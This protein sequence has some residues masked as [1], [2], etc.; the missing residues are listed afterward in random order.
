MKYWQEGQSMSQPWAFESFETYVLRLTFAVFTELQSKD[1]ATKFFNL[2]RDP[3]PAASAAAAAPAFS[4]SQQ[5]QQQPNAPFP[6]AS[7]A[8]GQVSSPDGPATAGLLVFSSCASLRVVSNPVISL[9][10]C[11]DGSGADL[12]FTRIVSFRP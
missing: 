8:P 1:L 5:P 9:V 12:L 6:N 7:A 4:S 3:P 10:V 2:L 11:L